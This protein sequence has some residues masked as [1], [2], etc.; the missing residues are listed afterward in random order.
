MG[1]TIPQT[2]E[3]NS[4]PNATK[5]PFVAFVVRPLLDD[6]KGGV[7]EHNVGVVGFWSNFWATN[8]PAGRNTMKTSLLICF[9]VGA[10]N[11]AC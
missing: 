7:A 1:T 5:R 6:K 4:F 11:V 3:Q 2:A 8:P 10:L 9:P